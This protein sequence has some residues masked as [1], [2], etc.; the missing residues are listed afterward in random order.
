MRSAAT[1][2]CTP[3]EPGVLKAAYQDVKAN[4]PESSGCENKHWS[5]FSKGYEFLSVEGMDIHGLFWELSYE[6]K[7]AY[8]LEIVWKEEK[9]PTKQQ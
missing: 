7:F 3:F 4:C 1:L 8:L 2:S 5:M 9:I 6:T